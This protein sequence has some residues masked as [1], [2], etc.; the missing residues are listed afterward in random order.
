MANQYMVGIDIGG[1]H[2]DAVLIN[3]K[4]EILKACKSSTTSCLEEGLEHVLTE[5]V[6]VKERKQITSI[7][8]GTTHALNTL[9]EGRCLSKVAVLRLAG[10]Q[11]G[12]LPAAAN[13]PGTLKSL[14]VADTLTLDGGYEFDGRELTSLIIPAALER[15][16]CL[17]D[18]GIQ[19]FALVGVFA[20]MQQEQELKLAEAMEQA[21]GSSISL[22]CSHN[23]GGLGFI[24]RENGTILNESI[25]EGMKQAFNRLRQV[26]Q[27]LNLSCPFYFTQN[28]GSV[29]EE[30][31]AMKFPLKT[32]LSG[33][34][35]SFV[36]GAKL[37]GLN[38][39]VVIDVGG[40]STD[41]GVVRNGFPRRTMRASLIGG[42]PVDFP[43]PDVYSLAIGGGSLVQIEKETF[44]I[45]PKSVGKHLSSLAQAFGGQLLTLTDASIAR[46]L[47]LR[48]INATSISLNAAEGNKAIGSAFNR[49]YDGINRLRGSEQHLPLVF[50]GGGAVLFA[51][52]AE[53]IGCSIP[54]HYNA[55]N[56]YGAALAEISHVID[57]VI[58][59][60]NRS[61]L[62]HAVEE[63]LHH[64]LVQKGA[65]KETIRFINKQIIPYHYLQ[66]NLARVIVTAA[67]SRF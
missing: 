9:L 64:H 12:L 48:G 40:T 46:G 7:S 36:G 20:P 33:P 51:P 1:T 21:F 45:G 25:K 13:W 56:A 17:I 55:A 42:I 29:I 61:S 23:I 15:I 2:T 58:A 19:N 41:I 47:H 35:N 65:K 18:K 24:E 50:V 60:D 34:T 4:K 59:L 67:G 63:E 49:I 43:A 53:K 57:R 39:A 31:E 28:N 5:L 8:I 16:A 3:S 11:P 32:M 10:H 26:F 52:E 44:H 54:L 6:D 14:I 62:M 30:G 27:R 22:T 37:A 38:D 66:G